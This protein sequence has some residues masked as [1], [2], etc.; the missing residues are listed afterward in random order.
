MK[1][2]LALLL[3]FSSAQAENR[4]KCTLVPDLMER[5]LEVHINQGKHDKA[6][7]RRVA[8]NF[9][10][11]MDPT[12]TLLLANEA[13]KLKRKVLSF[14][15]SKKC[16]Q[17]KSLRRQNISLHKNM[18]A[19]VKRILKNPNYKLRKDI[20]ILA[21]SDERPQPKRER[22]QS[23]LREELIH[24]QIAGYLATEVELKEAKRKLIHRYELI[25]KR[26]KEQTQEDFNA[27]F[28][29]VFAESL[30]PHSSYLSAEAIEDFRISMGLSLEGIG[31]VLRQEDGYT[32]IHEIVPGGPAD[33]HGDIKVKD[34]ITAVAQEEGEAVDVVDMSLRKVVRLIRGKKGT[35]VKLSILRQ[36]EKTRSLIRT[37][38]RDKVDLKEQAAKLRWERVKRG[39]RELKLAIIDLPSFYGSSNFGGRQCV[40]DL[41]ALLIEV[42]MEKADGLL[43]DLSRNSGGLL[44]HAVELTGLFLGT[45]AVVGVKGKGAR[46]ILRDE[47]PLIQFRAPLVVLSSR[48]SASA[49]EILA[50]AIKDYKRGLIVGDAQSYG[51][52]SVQN[53]ISLPLGLGALK[54]TTALFFRPGGQSTQSMGVEADILV[55]SAYDAEIFGESTQK[56]HLAPRSMD[57]FYSAS[58]NQS[59]GGYRPIT[60]K[61]IQKLSKLSKH[62]IEADG[63]FQ[64]QAEELEKAKKNRKF[65]K[66]ADLL[67]KKGEEEEK[68]E[69]QTTEEKKK[70]EEKLSI[71][72]K[73]A[74]QILA[75]LVSYR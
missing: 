16:S 38:T 57:A 70:E 61:I 65:I 66:V 30:D 50:G 37:I 44:H 73:E 4:L 48:V 63:E 24:F 17:L 12:R 18:L 40:D 5:L 59:K 15:K 10:R 19:F 26:I 60:A 8:D 62:R 20:Q 25:S 31:A 55:P 21:D 45:G 23:K 27:F 72:A 29:D 33:R 11:A 71:Q 14:L 43:L 56:N 9:L 67:E 52:G 54:V 53:V 28:L 58:A 46:Q 13:K 68:K 22:E 3:L 51:K 34:R 42:A 74:V 47:D 75:D 69:K 35:R 36:G 49:S 1:T 32:V 41:R 64:K 39:E 6:L 7:E 2:A